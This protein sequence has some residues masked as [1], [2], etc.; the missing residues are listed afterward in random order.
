MNTDVRCKHLHTGAHPVSPS[1][2]ASSLIFCSASFRPLTSQ[3][4][5]HCCSEAYISI[6]G[7]FSLHQMLTTEIPAQSSAH[8]E[9]FLYFILR[10]PL[11]RALMWL[12]FICSSH[13]LPRMTIHSAGV[14]L[15]KGFLHQ[16]VGWEVHK[17]SGVSCRR[18][19]STTEFVTWAILSHLLV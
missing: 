18:G 7:H 1:P 2:H 4:V 12:Q 3:P 9:N 16:P 13:V 14:L 19:I 11:P 10:P 17:N 8:Q 15:Q 5:S 6:F